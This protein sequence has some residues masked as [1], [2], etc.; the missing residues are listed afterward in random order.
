MQHNAKLNHHYIFTYIYVYIYIYI[1]ICMNLYMF[2][3][4]YIKNTVVICISDGGQLVPPGK[5]EEL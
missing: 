2:I 4:I 1:Y 3:Y 5:A